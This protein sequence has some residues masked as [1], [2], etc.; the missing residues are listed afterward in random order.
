MST[1][2][3]VLLKKLAWTNSKTAST[4]VAC[5]G[6]GSRTRVN[7][8]EL[9]LLL[10]RLKPYVERFPA[11]AFAYRTMRDARA[12]QRQRPRVTPYGF[13]CMGNSAMARGDYEPEEAALAQEL[14]GEADVFVDVGANIGFF[15]CL[16]RSAG[17]Q[18]VAV[19]PLAQNLDYLYA[20]LDANGWN[21]VEVNPIGLGDRPGIATLYGGGAGASLIRGW[22]GAS[23]LLKRKVSI[24]TLDILVGERFLGKRMFIKVDV[25]GTEFALLRGAENILRRTPAPIWIMEIGLTEHHPEGFNPEFAGTFDIFW[26]NGYRSWTAD[27]RRRAIT[28][29]DVE[30]WVNTRKK[31]FGGR[32]YLFKKG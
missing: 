28:R 4:P 15:S 7:E 6:S 2:T 17:K 31:E 20:N 26:N 8:K 14:L 10:N 11:L 21:D 23:S 25:E 24:S 22:A 13:L 30:N 16:A 32:N 29:E 19:E 1:L 27:A 12:F 9:S 18:T 3:E 5:S